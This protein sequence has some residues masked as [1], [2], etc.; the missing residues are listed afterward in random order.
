VFRPAHFPFP[1]S[2]QVTI[3]AMI[4]SGVIAATFGTI[5]SWRDGRSTVGTLRHVL[6]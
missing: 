1:V 6:S 2:A 5:L 3:L 4:G